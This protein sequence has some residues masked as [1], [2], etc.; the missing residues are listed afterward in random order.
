MIRINHNL[1]CSDRYST[2]KDPVFGV[3]FAYPYE[4]DSRGLV[5]AYNN[6]LKVYAFNES[7]GI[8][9]FGDC[10]LF[11]GVNG[12]CFYGLKV[13]YKDFHPK[14]YPLRTLSF[15]VTA[16]KMITMLF[17]DKIKWLKMVLKVTIACLLLTILLN[18][19]HI[20]YNGTF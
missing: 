14:A 17:E 4:K 20:L 2:K 1:V 8:F 13:Y 16:I 7:I 6:I 5:D 19:T 3:S 11:S 15:V 12:H 10:L 9:S 18:G